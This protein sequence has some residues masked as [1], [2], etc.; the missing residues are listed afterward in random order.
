MTHN[1]SNIATQKSL[2][3]IPRVDGLSIT[4]KIF[5][6]QYQKQGQPVLITGLLTDE[7]EW[8]LDYLCNTIGEQLFPIRRYDK[9]NDFQRGV[10]SGVES[11]VMS[12]HQYAQLLRQPQM[13][14]QAIYLGKCSL[15]NTPL[16]S[17]SVLK[18]AEQKIG[19]KN[20]ATS[21]NLWL[22]KGGHTTSL[23]YDALDGTL[24]QLCGEKEITLFPPSQLYNLY[25]LSILNH[26]LFG[27]KIRCNHSKIS[28]K[29][30]DLQQFPDF[31][32]ALKYQSK[33]VLHQGEMLYIPAGWWHEVR[34][35]GNQPVCSVNRWWLVSPFWRSITCWS[36]WRVHLGTLLATP[37]L[38]GEGLSI[39]FNK[40]PQEKLKQFIQK[41]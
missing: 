27:K 5:F 35:L 11:K 24:M 34:L 4:P 10:G 1:K 36:Q 13:N 38:L 32:K 20:P 8:N 23:H 15:K 41:L 14:H 18:N 26:L 17:S 25:P 31:K 19:L 9:N 7:P 40:N 28:L 6:E 3:F 37:H 29:N 2:N 22:G 16:A 12:L 21:L 39:I 30:P 33:I